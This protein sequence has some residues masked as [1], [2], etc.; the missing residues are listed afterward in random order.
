MIRYPAFDPPEYIDWKPD[1]E[2]VVDFSRTL[3]KHPARAAVIRAI[4]PAQLLAIYEGLVRNRLHDI[5]LKR[6]VKQGVIS[7]AWLGTGEEAA[8][9]GP[10]HALDRSLTRD[11]LSTDFV[12]P[13]I[14]NAGACHEMG[15]PLADMLRGYLGTADSPTRGRDLHIGDFKHGVL[16][17]ISHV[18]D[19]MAVTTGVA[20]SFKLSREPRVA[21]TWIGDGSTK[22]GVFHES[23]N[24]AAV[25]H[26]PMIVIIQDNKV[27]LGT[28][29]EQHHRGS[30]LDWAAAYG[31][32]GG[33]FDG[34]N[35]LDAYAATGLAADLCRTGRGPVLLIADTFRMGGHATHD[36]REARATFDATL[37]SHWGKRDPIGIYETYLI[38]STMDLESGRRAKHI[39]GLHEPNAEVLRSVESRV[40]KEVEQ[41]AREA[42]ES[43]HTNM[44]RGESA[45]DGVYAEAKAALNEAVAAS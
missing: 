31:V 25:Q 3:E 28:R 21:L 45:A 30:F 10:T 6:W 8:T 12:A 27:A 42:L 7:K 24:F 39:D 11:G 29:L 32:E 5:A 43:A 17:P 15:M 18:G 9:I 36:E 22:S 23:M 40:T 41:A 13:M 38:E 34:N 14:R 37:F 19:I 44:P 16:A 33:S 20:L 1:P 26:L 35:V 2:V 4:E